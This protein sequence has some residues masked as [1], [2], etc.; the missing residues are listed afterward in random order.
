[1]MNQCDTT[2][3]INWREMCTVSNETNNMQLILQLCKHVKIKKLNIII[4]PFKTSL[5]CRAVFKA[6][7]KLNFNV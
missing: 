7:I 3:Q 2:A 1:M 6:F 5:Y 4:C